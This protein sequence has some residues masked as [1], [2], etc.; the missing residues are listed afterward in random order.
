MRMPPRLQPV[1]QWMRRNPAIAA[2]GIAGALTT[3]GLSNPNINLWLTPEFGQQNQLVCY[4]ADLHNGT[5]R[6]IAEKSFLFDQKTARDFYSQ[7]RTNILA[8]P[9]QGKGVNDAIRPDYLCQLK[10]DKGTRLMKNPKVN[11]ESV[12]PMK[13][14]SSQP[15]TPWS[16]NA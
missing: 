14:N 10:W 8:N 16:K 15:I 5:P 2:A 6:N 13:S 12:F 7:N 11:G 1:T 4:T 9:F 3:A